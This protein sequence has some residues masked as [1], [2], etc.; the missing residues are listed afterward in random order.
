MS[1]NDEI[2]R[3]MSTERVCVCVGGGGGLY[4]V[5]VNKTRFDAKLEH[6]VGRA[7]LFMQNVYAK[8]F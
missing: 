5:V 4:M 6:F 3:E 1:S 7:N 8:K 2:C